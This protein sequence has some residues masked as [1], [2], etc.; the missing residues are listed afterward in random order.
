MSARTEKDLKE[1]NDLPVNQ[2]AA[3][4]LPQYGGCPTPWE[5]HALQL[6]R[7][8]LEAG[9]LPERLYLG[10]DLE[11]GLLDLFDIQGYNPK[12]AAEILNLEDLENLGPQDLIDE[13]LERVNDGQQEHLL[14]C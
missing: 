6:L 5:I 14:D 8:E 10:R 3:T 12:K 7:L 4:L 2:Y 13:L 9:H 1:V 11:A